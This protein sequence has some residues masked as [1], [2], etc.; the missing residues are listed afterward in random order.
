VCFFGWRNSSEVGD[1][2]EITDYKMGENDKRAGLM[3]DLHGKWRNQGAMTIRL[4]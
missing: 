3:L 4:R 2:D 1:L